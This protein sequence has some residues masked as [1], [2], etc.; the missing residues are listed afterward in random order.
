ML[1]PNMSELAT[2][3]ECIIKAVPNTENL[4]R[5]LLQPNRFPLAGIEHYFTAYEDH[6]HKFCK[7]CGYE[8]DNLNHIKK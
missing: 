2:L 3:P 4:K 8:E 7:F 1:F 5:M 6:N